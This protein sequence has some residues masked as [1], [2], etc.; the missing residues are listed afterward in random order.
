MALMDPAAHL[1]ERLQQRLDS[2]MQ[3]PPKWQHQAYGPLNAY[4]SLRFPPSHFLVKPQALLRRELPTD[5]SDDDDTDQSL[6]NQSFDQ[7]F[8]S[9]RSSD[10]SFE[11]PLDQ[12]L[13]LSFDSIDSHGVQVTN[14][15]LYPD[16]DID[17]YW[18]A[19]D[20]I[21]RSDIVRIVIEIASLNSKSRDDV[22]YQLRSYIEAVGERWDQRLVG[23]AILGNEAYL[24]HITHDNLRIRVVYEEEDDSDD[25]DDDDG[26]DNNDY[27]MSLFDPR[28]V[29][30]LDEMYDLSMDD[31]D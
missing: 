15:R 16:F 31:D 9:D 24:M 2:W 26:Q 25:S 13:D 1:P 29:E 23:I 21:N 20:D 4:F 18:G 27:W 28:V 5:D 6:S 3:N 11:P 14:E 8:A 7:S 10:Q 17:Q 12:P 19:G 22:V 30:V